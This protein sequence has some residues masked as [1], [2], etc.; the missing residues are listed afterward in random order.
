MATSRAKDLLY[1]KEH[2]KLLRAHI[3]SLRTEGYSVPDMDDIVSTCEDFLVE[4]ASQTGRVNEA[5]L[6]E[7]LSKAFPRWVKTARHSS[8]LWLRFLQ[9]PKP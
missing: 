8:C 6:K 3:T 4:V 1:V 7:R 2:S 9:N 5:L